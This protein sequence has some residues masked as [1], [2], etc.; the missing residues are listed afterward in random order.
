M[1]PDPVYLRWENTQPPHAKF[2]E[3]ETELSLFFPKQLVRR[4]GRLGGRPR[5][6]HQVVADHAELMRQPNAISRRRR[7]HGYDQV[8]AGYS[9]IGGQRAA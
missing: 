6:L 9:A 5:S 2:Y 8:D 4:W 1:S 7:H 3:V